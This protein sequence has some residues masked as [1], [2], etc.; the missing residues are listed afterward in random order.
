[1]SDTLRGSPRA[2]RGRRTGWWRRYLG[3]AVAVGLWLSLAGCAF[4]RP[5]DDDQSSGKLDACSLVD[6]GIAAAAIGVESVQSTDESKALEDAA[7]SVLS[8]QYSTDAEGPGVMLV[9][10]RQPDRV[11]AEKDIAAV[12]T[13]CP[14]ARPLEV[15]GVTGFTCS[16]G[17]LGGSQAFATWDGFIVHVAITQS[18]MESAAEQ[19]AVGLNQV[20][21]TLKR[22][23]ADSSFMPR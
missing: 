10:T 11:Q 22:T 19:A 3:A 16:S 23:L 9:A 8:C 21:A 7:G 1:M 20:V 18:R 15:D 13:S 14:E 6:R 12:Q 4:A 17:D 5:A 2:A